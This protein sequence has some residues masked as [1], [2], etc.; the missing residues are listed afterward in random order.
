LNVFLLEQAIQAH[1]GTDLILI[2][3]CRT[4]FSLQT[5]AHLLRLFHSGSSLR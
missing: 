2:C 4:I 3:W 1:R 5:R